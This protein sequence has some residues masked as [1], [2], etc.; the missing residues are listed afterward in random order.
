MKS[1]VLNNKEISFEEIKNK[2][3]LEKELSDNQKLTLDFCYEWLNG[4]QEF[5]IN[6]SGSTGTPKPIKLSREKM[7]ISAKLTGKY[8]DLK[9]GD[10]SL[11]VLSVKYIAGLMMIVRGFVLE[12]DMYIYDVTSNPLKEIDRSIKYDFASFV[13]LQ[14]Y[15][16][17]TNTP[18]KIN[19]LNSIKN[20]LIGGGVINYN[21]EKELI[22]LESNIYH[23]YGM[24]E[25]ITHIALRKVNGKD[26]KD[27]FTTLENTKISLDRRGCLVINSPVTDNIDIVTNDLAEIL[28]DKDFKILGRIDNVINTG[29]IKVQSEKIEQALDKA[30]SELDISAN[31]FVAAE[32]DDKFGEIITAVFEGEKFDNEIFEKINIKLKNYLEKYEIPKKYLSVEQ[33]KLTDTGKINKRKTLT[34]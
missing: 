14:I 22:N 17:I 26:K 18:E 23:T 13:P 20:I 5:V 4:Q 19:F 9:K 28:S 7:I 33:F 3:Y 1:L 12:M 16:I 29:G 6:T 15:E 24:T 11:I 31:F 8:L 34:K 10:K 30:L 2:S 32:K 27:Y 21:L 25:T